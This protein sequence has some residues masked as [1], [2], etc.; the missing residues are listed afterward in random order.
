MSDDHDLHQT[1]GELRK[2]QKT[3]EG[4]MANLQTT[5]DDLKATIDQSKGGWKATVFLVGISATIG[6]AAAK[7]L[8]FVK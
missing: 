4:Q 5:V 3:L 8:P 6:G 2:G 1:I 7:F